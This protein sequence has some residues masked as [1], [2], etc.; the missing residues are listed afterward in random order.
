MKLRTRTTK[1][2]DIFQ[3]GPRCGTRVNGHN[4]FKFNGPS[5]LL[6]TGITFVSLSGQSTMSLSL[7]N[8]LEIRSPRVWK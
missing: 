1:T 2:I 4:G 7:S 8:G 6:P 5:W 3:A